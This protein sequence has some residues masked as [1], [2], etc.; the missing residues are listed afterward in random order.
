MKRLLMLF[1]LMAFAIFTVAQVE[2][3]R[4]APKL[5]E[6]GGQEVSTDYFSLTIPKGW[7]MPMPVQKLPND[8]INVMFA[9]M[10]QAPAVNLTVMK[11]PG[12]AQQ[13]AE[14]TIA[15]MKKGG[16]QVTDPVEKDG[17]WQ[18]NIT[19]GKGKGKVWFGAAD[20]S[21]AVTIVTGDDLEK[22]DEIFKA[23]NV[24]IKGLFPTGVNE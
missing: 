5:K 7:S 13:M 6:M 3:A 16:M 4:P 12:T 15:N 8:S 21:A 2:A 17:L 11:S 10:S 22:A 24:R 14:V 9:H 18:A 1:V 19:Q 23:M 20:G